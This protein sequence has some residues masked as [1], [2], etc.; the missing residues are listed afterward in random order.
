LKITSWLYPA[1][2]E[3][4]MAETDG[5]MPRLKRRRWRAI[6]ARAIINPNAPHACMAGTPYTNVACMKYNGGGDAETICMIDLGNDEATKVKPKQP[7]TLSGIASFH[8]ME[9]EED[10]VR[11]WHVAGIGRGRLITWKEIKEHHHDIKVVDPCVEMLDVPAAVDRNRAGN[12]DA[13]PPSNEMKLKIHR[14]HRNVRARKKMRKKRVKERKIQQELNYKKEVEVYTRRIKEEN[15]LKCFCCSKVLHSVKALEKH[16]MNG[17]CTSVKGKVKW[18]DTGKRKIAA[19]AAAAA[20][21]AIP[22]SN[23]GEW[24]YPPQ[25]YCCY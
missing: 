14:S 23:E 2:G 22:A 10:G 17:G 8:Y 6:S 20:A 1:A 4:K 13:I 11:V 7:D 15:F 18:A 5:A 25:L 9:A 3:A 21:A 24:V 12:A 19:A 16:Q